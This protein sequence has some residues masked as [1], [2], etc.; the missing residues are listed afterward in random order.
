MKK[1]GILFRLIKK[2]V[3]SFYKKTEICGIENLPDEPCVIVSNHAQVH[4]P[5]ISELFFSK[6][7][8]I[9]TTGEM[10]KLKQIPSY[11]YN[12]FW[13]EKPK[14]TKWFYKILSYLIAPLGCYVF[15]Q[16]NTIGVYKDIRI[17]NTLKNSVL[18]LK[19]G[20]NLIIFPESRVKHNEIV[21]DFQKNFVDVARV[22]YKATKKQIKFVPSYV[23]PNLKKVVIG[24][25][26]EFNS[27]QDYSLEKDRIVNALK[28]A[29]T[30]IAKSL[31]KHTVIPYENVS[32]RKYLKSK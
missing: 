15:N 29:I 20:Y 8:Y 3:Y 28:S 27:N 23:A 14:A 30:D 26:I 11:A 12:D 24:R 25:P 2:I 4:G 5:I 9:W 18:K 13:Y 7:C 10:L 21:N 32:K 31:P 22:Y 6:N 17:A 1:K 19:S 16:A